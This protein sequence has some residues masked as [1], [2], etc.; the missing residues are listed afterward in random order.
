MQKKLFSAI[1]IIIFAAIYNW[2]G[3]FLTPTA[4]SHPSNTTNTTGSIDNSAQRITQAFAARESDL[5][6]QG[7]GIVSKV[8]PDDNH[9]SRHQRF[10]LKLDNGHSLLIAHNIDLAP[11]VP[12]LQ[13]GERVEF[14]GEYEWNEKGGVVHWTHHDPKKRH[15]DGWL[16][17]RGQRYQ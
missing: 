7:S 9:G 6:I 3:P 13:P 4:S 2:V 10:I 16:G 5:Q 12:D 1:A 8:L 15:V 11:R 17:Y 14:F